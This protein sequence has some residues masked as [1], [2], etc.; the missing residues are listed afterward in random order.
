MYAVLAY[1]QMKTISFLSRMALIPVLLL[2]ACVD[3][4]SSAVSGSVSLQQPS[5]AAR[6]T[7]QEESDG[8]RY[9]DPKSSLVFF[10]IRKVAG[11]GPAMAQPP[12]IQQMY[13]GETP[14][15][16]PGKPQAWKNTQIVGQNVRWYQEDEG[17]GADFPGFAT[18]VFSITNAKG[19]REYYK[20]IICHGMGTGYLNEIDS[21]LRGVTMR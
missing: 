2:T 8:V 12:L 1:S 13:S 4:G 17:S 11:P 5:L 16:P 18:E 7:S 15:P 3:S 21:W 20:I 6:W 9:T 14:Q 19:Q 10:Y